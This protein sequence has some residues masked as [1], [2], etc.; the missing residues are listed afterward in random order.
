VHPVYRFTREVGWSRGVDRRL[1]SGSR[2]QKQI[3]D[4]NQDEEESPE[5]DM[6]RPEAE[7]TPLPGQVRGWNVPLGMVVAVVRFGHSAAVE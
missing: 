6:K 3:E 4:Q 1:V 7:H 2:S 5:D